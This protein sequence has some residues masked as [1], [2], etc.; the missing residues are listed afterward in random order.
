MWNKITRLYTGPDSKSHFEDT[1]IPLD[2]GVATGRR[3]KD[4]GVVFHQSELVKATGVNFREV[5]GA[6]NLDWHNAP[7][8]Q[9][10]ITLEGEW[11]IEIGDGTK[12]QFGPGD[13][14]LVEDTMG[15]GHISRQVN[16]RPRKVVNV[17]LD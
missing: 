14:L 8:R 10:I 3:L 6:Y 17:I 16:N 7:H 12:R 15:Q 2:D 11:E 1:E 5:V 4:M 13:I 9:F